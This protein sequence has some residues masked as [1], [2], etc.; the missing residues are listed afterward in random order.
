MVA[1]NHGWLWPETVAAIKEAIAIRPTPKIAADAELVFI[2]DHGHRWV[3]CKSN[4]VWVDL[5]VKEF[6]NLVLAAGVAG[7]GV[8][9]ADTADPDRF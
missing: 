1:A 2:S 4:G 5:V 3:R 7:E 9:L 8:W 6:R